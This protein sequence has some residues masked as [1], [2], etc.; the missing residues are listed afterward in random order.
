MRSIIIA[1]SLMLSAGVSFAGEKSIYQGDVIDGP[2][3]HKNLSIFLIHGKNKVD[4]D[5]II[6]LD[7]AIERKAIII[8]ETG[9]VEELSV[10]NKGDVHVFIQ[11]GDIIKGGKQD[12]IL[13]SD[14]VVKPKSGKIPVASFCV[15][16]GR[17]S[18]RGNENHRQ[19]NSSKKAA[20]SKKLKLATKQAQLQ[21][22]VWGEV[23]VMQKK[24]GS[25]LG[26]SVKSKESSS[27]LQLTLENKE[28]EKKSE[29]Y[30]RALQNITRGK[31]DVI[32]FAFAINGVMNSTDI[33]GHA[34]LFKKLWNKM[35]ESCA[36]EAISE[37]DE[38][39]QIEKL[40]PEMVVTWLKESE[41]AKK[42]EERV[43]NDLTLQVKESDENVQ[44]ETYDKEYKDGYIH[45]N[46]IK[47]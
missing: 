1:L 38:K 16:Q 23:A 6:T 42:E 17:W 11:A 18:Q 7:E 4:A 2:Y 21:G 36:V 46:V 5:N 15:E 27:S 28:L 39:K 35:L 44:F 31:Q 41:K 10:E 43:M 37:Y 30:I 9:D 34:V 8:H 45:K 29:E 33:Y 32:G 3:S 14:L 12:R 25:R 47:K 19:F 24:L 26:E 20:V 22:D 40:T 13:R